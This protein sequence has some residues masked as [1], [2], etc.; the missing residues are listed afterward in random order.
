MDNSNEPPL[1]VCY[2]L[3]LTAEY[4]APAKTAAQCLFAWVVI[5]LTADGH[6]VFGV[7]K[8]PAR[9]RLS[10]NYHQSAQYLQIITE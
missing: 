4:V 9:R 1:H 3:P 6:V 7:L 8:S 2:A 10:P 5:Q